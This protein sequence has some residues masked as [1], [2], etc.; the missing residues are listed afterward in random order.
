M[1]PSK[2]IYRD[3]KFAYYNGCNSVFFWAVYTKYIAQIATP[4]WD[5]A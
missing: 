2:L 4:E 5:T 1:L 3:L